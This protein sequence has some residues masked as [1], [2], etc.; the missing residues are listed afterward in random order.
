MCFSKQ[1]CIRGEG[2]REST[3]LFGDS[4]YFWKNER[5]KSRH[6]VSTTH[7]VWGCSYYFPRLLAT[8]WNTLTFQKY[9][10]VVNDYETTI[11]VKVSWASVSTPQ[12]KFER[13]FIVTNK[14]GTWNQLNVWYKIINGVDTNSMDTNWVGWN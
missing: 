2:L 4:F 5:K 6:C 13:K 8:R 14:L 9:C 12:T 3:C 11:R 10:K 7:F 1:H